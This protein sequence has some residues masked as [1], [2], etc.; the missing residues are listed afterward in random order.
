MNQINISITN[1]DLS[2]SIRGILKDAPNKDDLV[3]LLSDVL[4]EQHIACNYF[5]T[6]ILGGKL[7]KFPA[8]GTIGSIKLTDL[9]FGFSALDY[10]PVSKQGYIRVIV[11]DHRNYNAYCPIVVRLPSIESDEV[12]G[13]I[14]NVGLRDFHD[15]GL[16][17]F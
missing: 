1:D 13:A 9:P 7:P 15:D 2:N 8:I 4:S 5:F 3:R 14:A 10:E 17:E 12:E 6:L 16:L 11:V